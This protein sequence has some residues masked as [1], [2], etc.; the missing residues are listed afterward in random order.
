S[1]D[2]GQNWTVSN[3]PILADIESAGIF[4]I[5]F[6]DRNHGM[7]VGGNYRKP[8]ESGATAAIT[9]DGGKTWT[10]VDQSL[11]FR[12]CV[13]WANDRWVAVGTSGS[14]MSP[15]DGAT[16]K[17]LGHENYNSVGFTSTGEGWAVGPKGRIAK[18]AH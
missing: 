7:I 4:S 14:N 12:S 11:S 18:F 5:C 8:D 2:R 9:S 13:A 16:W 17:S 15:D 10:L 3:T 6:R 1:N